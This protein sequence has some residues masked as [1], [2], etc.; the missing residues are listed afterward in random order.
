MRRPALSEGWVE[1]WRT[2]CV[3]A[4]RCAATQGNVSCFKDPVCIFTCCHWVCVF[5]YMCICVFRCL[6]TYVQINSTP[7]TNH[8]FLFWWHH[9]P[10][11]VITQWNLSIHQRPFLAIAAQYVLCIEFE[12]RG[13]LVGELWRSHISKNFLLKSSILLFLLT[14]LLTLFPLS[15]LSMVKCLRF[16]KTTDTI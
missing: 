2:F 14:F 8:Q 7:S 3:V 4:M 1:N 6:C 9:Q 15:L 13:I 12:K 5:V 10:H 16:L 11:Y